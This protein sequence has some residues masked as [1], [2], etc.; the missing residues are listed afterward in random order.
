MLCGNKLVVA[1]FESITQSATNAL[2]VSFMLRRIENYYIC[3]SP[4]TDRP[5]EELK[6]KASQKKSLKKQKLSMT[7]ADKQMKEL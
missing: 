2:S 5:E 6:V 7:S 1:T 3:S 4:C